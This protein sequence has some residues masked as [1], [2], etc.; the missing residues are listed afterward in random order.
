[1][2]EANQQ[3]YNDPAGGTDSTIGTQ[4]RTDFFQKKALIEA[5]KTQFF[6]QLSSTIGMPKN[7]GKTIKRFHYVPLLDDANIN[8]QGINAAGIATVMSVS[9][10]VSMAD[11]TVPNIPTDGTKITGSSVYFV[12]EG[13][14][15]AAAADAAILAIN[16]WSETPV[17]AGG[18]GVTL[19]GGDEDIKFA[20]L[21]NSTDGL[22][23]AK[24][25]RFGGHEDA[26]T[27]DALAVPESGNLYGSSKDVGTIAAKL[28]ALGENGGRVNRVGFKRIELSGTFEKFGFFDEYNQES[29]DFDSDA[30]L[31]SHINREMILGANE[32]TEDALQI[33]LLNSAGVVRFGG[34]ATQ[35]SEV[36]GEGTVSVIDYADL[37][38]LNISLDNN[39]TPKN[40]KIIAGTRMVDTRVINAA[41]VMYIGSELILTLKEMQDSFSN[42][43]F[44]SVEKYASAG[45]IM[46]G[47]IG[48]IDQFRIVVVPEMMHWEGAGASVGTNP[49]Y[50]ETGGNY[51]VYPMLVVGSEAFVTVGFQTDGKAVK[52]KIKHVKP[53]SDIS[54]SKDD[55]YGEKGFMSI[56]WYY[57]FMLL[58]PE[59]I[60][61]VKTV[62]KW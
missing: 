60:A 34:V 47:E 55:P 22:G 44:I 30:E 33:D 49:G 26:T 61:L 5:K 9:I 13:A 40:T 39:R 8:D 18:L 58:R 42:Q 23:Y 21:V 4:L 28:P 20:D 31:E 52:F 15:A 59:R 17:V 14:N 51:D 19:V 12:G 50:R 11:G 10:P 57:G 24:G 48:T 36:S 56:K 6:G 41:R 32:M 43:A 46:E 25:F 27:I 29:L 16:T 54:Y 7:M 35:D 62:A 53:G 1:M 3:M 45:N 37:I 2:A 38:R